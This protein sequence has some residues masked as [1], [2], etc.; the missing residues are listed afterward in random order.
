VAE[1]FD[2]R[3]AARLDDPA[4]ADYQPIADLLGL[5]ALRGDET[6]VD[7][8]AGVGY[9][10]VPLAAALPRG[11]VVAVDRSAEL[12]DELRR[13]VTASAAG[14]APAA[15]APVEFVHTTANTVPLPDGVADAILTVNVWHEIYDDQSALGEL[16][17]LLAPGGALAIVDW[18]PVERPVGPPAARILTLE[19]ALAVVADMGLKADTVHPA[20]TLFDYYYAIVARAPESLA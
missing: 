2:P 17:R 7:Y 6:V 14:R 18:A 5:L 19:Q 16:R 1:P 12:L 8:G 20:G 4:R 10:T 15:T 13:R 9:T 3:H 11:L